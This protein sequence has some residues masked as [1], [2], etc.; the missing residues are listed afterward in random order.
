MSPSPAPPPYRSKTLAA[1]LA[2]VAGAL[3]LHRIYLH[4][5]G[6]KLAW[7]H[8]P[9]TTLGL[10]GAERMSTL[11][12]NDRLAWVLVPVLGLMLSQAMLFAILYALTPDE[13]WDARYNP[14]QPTH[15]TRWGAVLAAVAALVVGGVVLIGTI[16]FSIQ[17][18]FE[19]QLEAEQTEQRR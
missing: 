17:K 2:L 19:T 9:L 16:A 4:G 12:Q 1:W 18:I 11:G 8:V 13:R 3:G 6:D 5:M 7:A 15:P 10:V 14:D